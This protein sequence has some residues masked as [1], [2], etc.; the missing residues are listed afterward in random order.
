MN[1]LKT[2]DN[3]DYI[4]IERIFDTNHF[5]GIDAENCLCLILQTEFDSKPA[6]N[7]KR[8]FLKV[9]YY[10]DLSIK[11]DDQE[12]SDKFC[13]IKCK[14]NNHMVNDY[15]K[16][17][18]KK[19][20]LDF[21]YSIKFMDINQ[22][23]DLVAKLFETEKN[24]R[25]IKQIGLWG[26]LIC[27]YIAKDKKLMI[28]S[29][30]ADPKDKWD[31]VKSNDILEVKTYSGSKR[32]HHFR[33]E[34]LNPSQKSNLIVASLYCINQT[35]GDTVFDLKRNILESIDDINLSEKFTNTFIKQLGIDFLEED[36][37]EYSLEQ[38][39]NEMRLISSDDVPKIH[40]KA[41]IDEGVS[42]IT[43]ISNLEFTSEC[44][45]SSNVFFKSLK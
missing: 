14:A 42:N 24:K 6:I 17:F 32:E 27:I 34:Q 3:E 16:V 13:I 25:S 20:A 40:D 7:Q 23:L 41:M 45:E 36:A 1:T 11:I 31:F 2:P 19:I 12:F 29:W 26:E 10:E 30:H 5:F 22:R 18:G 4:N 28:N 35:S 44:A 15:F 21:K 39:I 9:Y 37:H 33:Y 38:S 8:R 43:F